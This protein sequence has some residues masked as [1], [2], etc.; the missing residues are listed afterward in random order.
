MAID[1]QAKGIVVSS[2]TGITAR[3]VSRFRCPVD[4]IGMTTSEEVWRKL[5]LSWGVTPTLCE[6]YDSVDVIF[7][8]AKQVAKEV[9]HLK[10]KDNI[11]LTGG[12]TSG[13]IGS[14]NTI[15][16]ETI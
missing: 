9:L 6:E 3:L 13:K 16:V 11:V 7:Y 14:T 8:H 4:I 15:R 2:I 12:K 1:V 5:N 10:E